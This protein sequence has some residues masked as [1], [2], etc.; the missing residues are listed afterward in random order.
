M[1]YIRNTYGVPAKR[2]GRVEYCYPEGSEPRAGT[3]VGSRGAK[4]RI[5]L[6]GN[7][8]VGNYHPTWMLRY[9]AM[10]AA[11]EA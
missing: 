5:R 10:D 7:S 2:G 3:I 1:E 4:L 11:K 9:A 8:Y 6:D